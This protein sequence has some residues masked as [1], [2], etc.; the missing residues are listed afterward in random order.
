MTLWSSSQITT[1]MDTAETVSYR[2]SDEA[3]LTVATIDAFSNPSMTLSWMGTT[4]NVCALSQ[5]LVVNV[6]EVTVLP[7]ESLITRSVPR[8]VLAARLASFPD[9]APTEKSNTTLEAGWAPN[10]RVNVRSV[11][12]TT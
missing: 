5:L 3:W 7:P 1:S 8:V 10:T 12:L 9:Q 11:P 4:V 6:A 2:L